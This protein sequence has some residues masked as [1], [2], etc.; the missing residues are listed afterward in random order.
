MTEVISKPINVEALF[1]A[2]LS[3]V[4]APPVQPPMAATG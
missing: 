4:A 1:S 2:L 3:A